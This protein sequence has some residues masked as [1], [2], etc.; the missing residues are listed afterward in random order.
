MAQEVEWVVKKSAGSW[1]N[2]RRLQR[3]CQSVLEQDHEPQVA[4]CVKVGALYGS[5][6][7][8]GECEVYVEEH[9][10]SQMTWKKRYMN[11]VHLSSLDIL[12]SSVSCIPLA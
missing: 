9:F 6:Y 1:F 8:Q 3:M 2:P 7:H 5:I 12:P 11:A 4:S 10:V